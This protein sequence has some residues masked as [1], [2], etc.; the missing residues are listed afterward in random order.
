MIKLKKLLTEEVVCDTLEEMNLRKTIATG[1][2]G[3]SSML[4][5]KGIDHQ[6]LFNQIAD[7][8]GIRQYAYADSV[9]LPTI[10]V[11][12]NLADKD[13]RD[14]LKKHNVDLRKLLGKKTKLSDTAIINLYKHSLHKAGNDVKSLIKNF[15]SLPDV[16]QMVLIDMSFNLGKTRLAKFVNM[17][18]AVERNDYQT[19]ADEMVDSKW[20]GQVKRRG[21]KL[22]SMMRSA[23]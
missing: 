18:S 15:D 5:L 20:Y 23:K 1:I 6:K 17:I 21:V 10:G 16:V 7:H 13:N 11:G 12:F 4:P 9:G 14:F 22:V 19:A 2:M 8:E 3:L